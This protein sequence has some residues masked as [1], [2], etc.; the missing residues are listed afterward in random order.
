MKKWLGLRP[1]F[2]NNDSTPNNLF[3]NYNPFGCMEIHISTH[4][5][6]ISKSA[7]SS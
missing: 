6:T 5:V 7:V 3:K 2:C 4:R 1:V